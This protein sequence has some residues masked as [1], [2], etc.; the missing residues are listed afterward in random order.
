MLLTPADP[1]A[2]ACDLCTPRCVALL[3]RHDPGPSPD[4][5]SHTCAAHR[6]SSSTVLCGAGHGS[7]GLQVR[8]TDTYR[9]RSWL[10]VACSRVSSSR[11]AAN[12]LRRWH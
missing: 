5:R 12:G 11:V 10:A 4:P 6:A 9:S 1:C 3:P 2:D 8:V 7:G